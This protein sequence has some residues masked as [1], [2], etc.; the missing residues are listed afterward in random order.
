LAAALAFCGSAIGQTFVPT[1]GTHVGNY[2][3]NWSTTPFPNGSGVAAV[4]PARTAALTVDLSQPITLGSLTINKGTSGAFD[5]TIL[6]SATNALTFDGVAVPAIVNGFSSA[7]GSGATIFEAPIVFNSTITVRQGDDNGLRFMQPLSG[8]GGLTIERDTNATPEGVVALSNANSYAGATLFRGSGNDNSLVVRLNNA[9]AIPGGIDVVGGTSN[10]TLTNSAI[11]GLGSTDFRRALGTG[12]DQFQF[13]TGGRSGWAAFVADRVVNIGGASAEFNW[14]TSGLGQLVFSA[15]TA[16]HTVDFQNPL[17]FGST[18]R[19]IRVLDGSAAIDAVISGGI[20]ATGAAGLTKAGDGTLRVTAASNY[21]GPTIING[22]V[23]LLNHADA[24]PV[25]SNL[26]LTSAAVVGLGVADF[27]RDLGTAAGQIQFTGNGGFS[28]SGANR[29]VVLNAG[30]QLVWNSGNFVP[31]GNN[32]VLSWESADATVDFQ[33]PIE[34]AGGQRTLAGRNGSAAIDGK[35]SGVISG[36]GSSSGITKTQGGTLELSAANT[37]E[38]PTQINT[39]VLLVT[40]ANSIPGGVLGGNI[41]NISIGGTGG[42]LGLGHSDF[43]SG[44]GTGPGQIQFLAAANGGFA[45]YGANRVVN[46]GGA[47]ATVTWNSDS[48]VSAN[49]LLSAIGADATVDF[50][51]PIDLN[52]AVRV[53]AVR[54]GTAAVDGVLSG[55][56]SGAGGSLQ[57]NAPGTLIVTA[58]NTYDGGT[59]VDNGQLLVNN[60]SGSGLGTG[61]VTVLDAATVGGN[62]TIGTVADASN[63]SVSAGGRVAPGTGAGTLTVFGNV[64]FTTG[65]YFDV[66]LAGNALGEFDRLAINGDVTLSGALDL[67]FIGSF[68]PEAGDSFVVL[69]TSGNVTGTFASIAAPSIA[70]VGW[71]AV[72]N[73]NSVVLNAVAAGLAGDFNGDGTV[74]AADYVVWRKTGGT[75]EAYIAWR[76]NFG[77]TQNPGLSGNH[78][79]SPASVPEPGVVMLAGVAAV[80]AFVRRSR[81]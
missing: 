51:N 39:G 44:L 53:V 55:V 8:S 33:N 40:N 36:V 4:L 73:A 28:A 52:G 14:G 59:I 42:A 29:K 25:A 2:D 72:Y 30:A 57:K 26:T 15:P 31:A 71:E 13:V 47:S 7:A 10:I 62:G 17:N 6:G 77:A 9:T 12:P 38:G 74:D 46:L 58:A 61:D 78:G 75:P 67:Q 5:T 37:Y 22:G 80:A 16:D 11:I 35:I 45:A 20:A 81:S 3:P 64:T 19:V 66:E 48:F 41:N 65:A 43:T 63:V 76:S 32:L 49:L 21:T 1:E 79:G 54:D 24:L 34:L 60:T 70:G 69:T 23:L 27:A 56:V 68:V 50:Q 18:A